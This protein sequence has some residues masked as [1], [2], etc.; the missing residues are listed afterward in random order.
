MMM[1]S[2]ALVDI[3]IVIG[4]GGILR[5]VR[6]ASRAWDGIKYSIDN[7]NG[8]LGTL[9]EENKEEHTEFRKRI[10]KV[11]NNGGNHAL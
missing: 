5:G 9:I 8:K 4:V 6:N 3:S 7:L 11:E 2:Q 10:K 1:A